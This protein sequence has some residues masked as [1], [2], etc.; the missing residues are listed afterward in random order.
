MTERTSYHHRSKYRSAYRHV[1]VHHSAN[2]T[3]EIIEARLMQAALRWIPAPPTPSTT[4]WHPLYDT[5]SE[6]I[7]TPARLAIEWEALGV[8]VDA[9]S[10]FRRPRAPCGS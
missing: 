6:Q 3:E 7:F 9:A 2:Y 5:Q 8:R 10:F 4:G 1:V